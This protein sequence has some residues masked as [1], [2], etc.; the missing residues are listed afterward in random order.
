MTFRIDQVKVST[1]LYR[2]IKAGKKIILFQGGTGAGKTVN[3]EKTLTGMALTKESDRKKIFAAYEYDGTPLSISVVGPSFPHMRRGSLRDWNTI[4][5]G[6]KIYNPNRHNKTEQ[7]YTYPSKSFMEF[8]SAE[9]EEKVRG[10]GRKILYVN[11]INLFDWETVRQ[12]LVRTDLFMVAD[13]NPIDE[14]HWLYDELLPRPDCHYTEVTHF[15]NPFLSK[16]RR[17]EIERAKETDPEWYKVYGLGQR[18][19]S[20]GLIYP[21]FDY[22]Y[23]DLKNFVYAVDFGYNVATAIGKIGYDRD[24]KEIHCKQLFY[25]RY[26]TNPDLIVWI[27]ANIPDYRTAT[28]VCDSAEPDRIEEMKRAGIKA[29]PANKKIKVQWV[30]GHRLH[31]DKFSADLVKEARSYKFQYDEK[32]NSYLDEPVKNNDHLMDVLK[33]GAAYFFRPTQTTKG[34]A[35]D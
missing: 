35:Y 4:M 9:N 15:D 5:E 11:E 33:Y 2:G 30:K 23:K 14:F 24:A 19:K 18:G 7:L 32:R 28:F 22:D 3:I 16:G 10:P 26:I 25:E 17:Q 27:K 8:F 31:F 1:E 6:G 20:S 29:V 34:K 13:Y 12:L 21:G